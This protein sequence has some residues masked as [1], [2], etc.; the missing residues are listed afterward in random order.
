MWS[1]IA[2]A[3]PLRR[4]TRLLGLASVL[5]VAEVMWLAAELVFGTRLQ[6]PAGTLAT[7]PLD[8]APLAVAL[9]S[10]A[11]SLA[12]WA[13]LVGLE[14]L[15]PHARRLWLGLALAALGASLYG[16]LTGTGVSLA[17]RLL[18]VVMHAAVAA[19][20]IAV[21]YRTS[22]VHRP[23]ASTDAPAARAVTS[24]PHG[25]DGSHAAHRPP[26]LHGST[27]SNPPLVFGT[28][29]PVQDVVAVIDDL[30]QARQAEAAL[31]AAGIPDG[32]SDVLEPA[33]VLQGMQVMQRRRGW[34]GGL[35]AGV[36]A[37]VSD[38]TS[39]MRDYRD[40]ARHGHS[41][42][43][44]HAATPAAVQRVRRVLSDFGAHAMHHY[45][46]FVVTDL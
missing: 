39:H 41:L 18:L 44:V 3:L 14:R 22:T 28:L 2:L 4:R 33:L 8:I 23:R 9:A 7:T 1:R 13:V 43:V 30:G 32:D 5:L 24:L 16:P 17:D 35:A 6:A 29:Y 21:L 25:A 34:L 26:V 15:T 12:G 11:L 45:G 40:E 10:L 37:L 31:R 27:Q 42:L 19:T 20:W 46:R 36:S 38:D